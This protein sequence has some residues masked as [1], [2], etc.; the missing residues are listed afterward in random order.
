MMN[1]SNA[2][3]LDLLSKGRACPV[4]HDDTV[5]VARFELGGRSSPRRSSSR[6]GHTI[7]V[8]SVRLRRLAPTA[9]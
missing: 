1:Q 5:S 7:D 6:A 3:R 2:H 9:R 8:S 4:S